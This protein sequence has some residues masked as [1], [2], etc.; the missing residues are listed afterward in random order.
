MIV[1][2]YYTREELVTSVPLAKPYQRYTIYLLKIKDLC[3]GDVV[4]VQSQVEATNDNDFGVMFSHGL[5]VHNTKIILAGDTEWPRD[6]D[7]YWWNWIRPCIPSGENITPKTHH[8]IRNL[9]GSFT[10]EVDGKHF[11]S[12]IVYSASSAA[13]SGD[14]TTINY[15]NGGISAVVF[16]N[17]IIEVE[18]ISSGNFSGQFN[19]DGTINGTYTYD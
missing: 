5:M 12:L 8:T 16:K 2:H 7:N 1:E 14:Y 19:Q 6:E 11:I 13:K 3:V 10:A 4:M 15:H 18:P 17:N 9:C